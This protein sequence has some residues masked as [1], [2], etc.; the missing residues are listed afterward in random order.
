M[1]ATNL[2]VK[3]TAPDLMQPTLLSSSQ[4][5]SS[6][7]L[8]MEIYFMANGTS[9][10]ITKTSLRFWTGVGNISPSQVTRLQQHKLQ[11]NERK[12][13]WTLAWPSRAQLS[14]AQTASQLVGTEKE[15]KSEQTPANFAG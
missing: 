15:T 11:K 6:S 14:S 9:G 5:S 12:S 10:I 2:K 13:D 8:R 1:L 7:V 4:H 3:K